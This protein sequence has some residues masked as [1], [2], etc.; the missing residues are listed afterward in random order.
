MITMLSLVHWPQEEGR[1]EEDEI[2]GDFFAFL[3]D[4]YELLGLGD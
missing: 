1:I 2:Y 4:L 3:K